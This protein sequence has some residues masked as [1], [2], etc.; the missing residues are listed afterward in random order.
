MKRF[1]GVMLIVVVLALVGCSKKADSPTDPGTPAAPAASTAT[2][3]LGVGL[4]KTD[5]QLFPG[6][7]Q[8]D[9]EC[10]ASVMYMGT[11][12]F[13]DVVVKVNGINIPYV[14]LRD[15]YILDWNSGLVTGSQ[16]KIDFSSS[17][18]NCSVT[19]NLPAPGTGQ[20]Q[21][22]ITGCMQGSYLSLTHVN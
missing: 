12:T 5:T 19:A 10:Y 21:T 18:G 11:A 17:V 15:L 2:V 20:T 1:L 16:V 4:T 9:T 7:P 8:P 6:V 13:K 3:L 14:A 22:P